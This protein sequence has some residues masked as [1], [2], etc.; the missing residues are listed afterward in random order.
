MSRGQWFTTQQFVDT[1]SSS[2]KS[3]DP[4]CF[5]DI[6]PVAPTLVL[7]DEAQMQIDDAMAELE[8]SDYRDWV[9]KIT[10]TITV[11]I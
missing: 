2:E 11:G 8:A 6:V 5:E 10:A 9:C 3:L 4:H 1:E 7:P